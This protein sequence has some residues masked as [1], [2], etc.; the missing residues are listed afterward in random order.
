MA[1]FALIH[2]QATLGGTGT[3]WEPSCASAVMRWWRLACRETTMT[4]V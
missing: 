1:T 3:W 2:G 4:P